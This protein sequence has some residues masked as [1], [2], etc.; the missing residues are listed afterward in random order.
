MTPTTSRRITQ[1][2]VAKL[3]GVSQKTVSLVLN[4]D[5]TYSIPPETRQKVNDAI[6]TLGYVPHRM[7][8]GLRNNKTYTIASII[9]D[10]ANP[11]YPAFLRGVQD[12]AEAHQ[13]DIIIY[14][15]D[16]VAEK[17][18][19]CLAS[20]M[21]SQVDGII[22]MF[23]FPISR[24]HLQNITVPFVGINSAIDLPNSDLVYVD[25]AEAARVVTAYLIEKGHTRI[26]FISG[27]PDLDR[28]VGYQKALA[29]YGLPQD[30]SLIHHGNFL[31]TSGYRAMQELLQLTP[32]PS[33]VFAANDLMALGAY[34]AIRE[35]GLRIPED[36]AVVGFDDIP[37]AKMLTPALTTVTQFQETL[38]RRVAEMMFERLAGLENN[39]K[40][41][42]KLPFQLI[43]RAST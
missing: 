17:E 43:V 25:C 4:N 19:H 39:E 31:E 20:A 15:T 29:D 10:I 18:K 7:A 21:E 11:F 34:Q 41:I 36:I 6:A 3:A 42:E 13:Y 38:G 30:E 23:F 28:L 22:G 1:F 35:A 32:R 26:G 37:A 24:E 27:F 9:P 16:G 5:A 33:A 12:V 2:D 14:N 40:R 8:R